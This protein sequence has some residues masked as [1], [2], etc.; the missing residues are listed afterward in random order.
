MFL[1]DSAASRNRGQQ[2]SHFRTEHGGCGWRWPRRSGP[3]AP[4]P[5][6]PTT[7][8]RTPPTP[9]DG[10]AGRLSS[11]SGSRPG[12]PPAARPPPARCRPARAPSRPPPSRA[13]RSPYGG[14]IQQHG[15][16]RPARLHVA[17]D[18][19]C[20]V[21]FLAEDRGF[22]VPRGTQT[23][24]SGPSLPSRPGWRGSTPRSASRFRAPK[25]SGRD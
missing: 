25:S 4:G 13:G 16:L 12:G 15:G 21:C 5:A 19:I 3:R 2:I 10:P 11:G 17:Q 7:C 9:P 8:G 23:W 6:L 22:K 14:R 1:L 20:T 18:D 24:T